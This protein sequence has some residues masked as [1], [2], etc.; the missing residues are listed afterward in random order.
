MR[1]FIKKGRKYHSLCGFVAVKTRLCCGDLNS[2]VSSGGTL[3]FGH[4]DYLAYI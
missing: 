4:V 3:C 2:L 1:K